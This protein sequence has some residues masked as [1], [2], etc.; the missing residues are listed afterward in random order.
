MS[1]DNISSLGEGA[2][3]EGDEGKPEIKEHSFCERRVDMVPEGAFD[4]LLKSCAWEEAYQWIQG[5]TRLSSFRKSELL[6]LLAIVCPNEDFKEKL[7]QEGLYY[8]SI[9]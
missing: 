9:P 2:S 6:R 1:V 7:R 8:Y 4:H 3:F 5:E